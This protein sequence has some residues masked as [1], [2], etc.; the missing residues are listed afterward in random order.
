MSPLVVRSGYTAAHALRDGKIPPFVPTK[1]TFYPLATL[2][3]SA[4]FCKRRARR[5]T[6]FDIDC[7]DNDGV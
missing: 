1:R 3:T 7:K 5:E 2:K 6:A 4:A